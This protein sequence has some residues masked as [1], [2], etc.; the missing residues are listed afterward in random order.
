MHLSPFGVVV[1]SQDLQTIL[2]ISNNS[3]ECIVGWYTL[4]ARAHSWMVHPAACL[5]LS[6][7][8][9]SSMYDA[10]TIG[11]CISDHLARKTSR[12]LDSTEPGPKYVVG[13]QVN[14]RVDAYERGVT[15]QK[16]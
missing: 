12:I 13:E 3:Y 14:V 1:N 4:R 15:Y 9:G 7:H 8:K 16:Q 2:L 6:T 5:L 11:L 10:D